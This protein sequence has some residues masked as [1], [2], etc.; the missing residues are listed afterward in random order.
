MKAEQFVDEVRRMRQAQKAYLRT[1]DK[2]MLLESK[3]REQIVD[4]AIAEFNDLD[5][6]TQETNKK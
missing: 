4:R 2:A 6:F 5:L 3:K 1:R